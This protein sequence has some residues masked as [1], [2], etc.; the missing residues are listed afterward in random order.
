[1]LLLVV[2]HHVGQVGQLETGLVEERPEPSGGLLVDPVET[3]VDRSLPG[4]ELRVV[5]PQLRV[6]ELEVVAGALGLRPSAPKHFA[7]ALQRLHP[8]AGGGLQR[9]GGQADGAEADRCDEIPVR[10]D[11]VQTHGEREA[12]RDCDD[13]PRA[14]VSNGST[15]P[16]VG[17]QDGWVSTLAPCAAPFGPALVQFHGGFRFAHRRAGCTGDVR[18]QS[19]NCPQDP[20]KT[21]SEQGKQGLPIPLVAR[22]AQTR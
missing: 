12:G 10:S 21:A 19:A 22:A 20:R 17:T 11:P 13:E 1:M 3:V 5:S 9:Q 18:E 6:L 14:G 2:E 8:D 7:P 4:L 16:C 15:G